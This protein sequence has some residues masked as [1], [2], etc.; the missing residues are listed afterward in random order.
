LCRVDDTHF[1]V[2]SSYNSAGQAKYATVTGATVSVGARATVL[3]TQAIA[4]IAMLSPTLFHFM[5][6]GEFNRATLSG[7]TLT[8]GTTTSIG[9]TQTINQGQTMVGVSSTQSIGVYRQTANPHSAYA[10]VVT[11]GSPSVSVVTS[12]IAPSAHNNGAGDSSNTQ[13]IQH[14]YQ[15][16]HVSAV[17]NGSLLLTF[18]Q[19]NYG[20]NVIIG[21]E[22]Y[23]VRVGYKNGALNYGA[24]IRGWFSSEVPSFSN[25]IG[26]AGNNA[27]SM[28]NAGSGNGVAIRAP[29]ALIYNAGAAQY[30]IYLQPIVAA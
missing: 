12:L 21:G 18:S 29:G 4:G 3:A 20:S 7:T 25:I 11:D 22:Y 13:D 24:P 28:L 8:P 27:P 19:R 5:G 9:A 14:I 17:N 16:S 1:I 30:L 6:G 10:A 15:L 26:N 2:G 23:S